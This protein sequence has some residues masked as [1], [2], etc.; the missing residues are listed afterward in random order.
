[1]ATRDYSTFSMRLDTELLERIDQDAKTAGMTRT[2][3]VLSYLP[4]YYETSPAIAE[5]QAEQQRRQ[6]R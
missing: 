6:R 2:A 1:M 3:Y 4:E 5:S